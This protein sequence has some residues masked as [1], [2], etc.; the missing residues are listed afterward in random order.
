[1]VDEMIVE[2]LVDV[3]IVSTKTLIIDGR[4]LVVIKSAKV[5]D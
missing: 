2:K 3:L 5:V 1:M 4:T